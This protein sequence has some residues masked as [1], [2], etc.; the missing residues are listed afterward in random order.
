MKKFRSLRFITL[1]LSA[2]MMTPCVMADG[3]DKGF[4]KK[5]AKKV[6]SLDSENIFNA[7]TAIPD[8]VAKGQSGVIIARHDY[9]E[10]RREEQNTIYDATG[11][12]NRTIVNHARRSMVKLLDQSAVERY[13]EFEFGGNTVRRTYGSALDALGKN[14][15]GARV[16]KTDGTVVDIDPSQALEVSDGKKGGKNKTFK[17]AIPSLQAGD[18]IEYFYYSEYMRERGD[19]CGLDMD[20]SDRYP[21]MTRLISGAFDPTLS[22]EFFSYNGA[23][24]VAVTR[25]D[26]KATARMIINNVPAVTFDKFVFDERQLPFVRLNVINNY[27]LPE[28]DYFIASTS[29]RGGVYNAINATSIINEAKEYVIRYDYRL[30]KMPRP[31]SPIP[32]QALKMVKDYA[33]AH[34]GATPRQLTDAAYLAVRYCNHV[35]DDD[36][37]VSSPFLLAMFMHDVMEKLEV[38]PV[39]NMGIGLI[40]SRSEVPAAELSGWNQSNFVACA[41]DSVYL[42]F[43]GFNIAPGELPGHFQGETGYCFLGRLRDMSRAAPVKEF[44]VRDRRYSGNYVKAELTVNIA[45][46]DPAALDVSR[47]VELGGSR[48]SEGDD[49]VDRAEWIRGVEGFFGL[50]KK[51]YKIKDYDAP[52]REKELRDALAKECAAVTGVKPDSVMSYTVSQRGFLP[53][54]DAMKYSMECRVSGLVENLGNDISVTLG[55]LLG[56]VD[57]IEGS[58][59]ER[60]LDAMLPSAFQDTHLLTLKV[61]AGYKVDPTSLEDFKRSVANAVGIFFVN[62]RVNDSGDVEVQCAMRVKAGTVPLKAWPLLRDL[63]D[64]GSQFAE[65]AIVLVRS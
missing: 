32:A 10:V 50:T 45:A 42:M 17:I 15:F 44:S 41:G 2:L 11:R 64:A 12:T 13:S 37:F 16:H 40:N 54:Q 23:P 34:P 18:V 47:K 24:R 26:N 57:K 8:S 55:R 49:L 39:E 38:F 9:F 28:E 61:P 1:M 3:I 21:V 58:E 51:P 36:D 35:A 52:A 59:R 48:K 56:H 19:I 6:W 31:L 43:P 53:G 5:A 30:W 20:L 29:R 62:A 46:D 4:F 60:L 63:Y 33:K 14:A 27:R 25:E 22:S 65:A 7:A